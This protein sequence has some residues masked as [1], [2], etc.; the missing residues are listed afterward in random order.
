M[1]IL[2]IFESWN[3]ARFS[4][5]GSAI[6][7]WPNTKECKRLGGEI[8]SVIIAEGQN[9]KKLFYSTHAAMKK[10]DVRESELK[11]LEVLRKIKRKMR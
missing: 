5:F 4:K 3:E 1:I 10:E 9:K 2:H 6:K 11:L 8:F 7:H